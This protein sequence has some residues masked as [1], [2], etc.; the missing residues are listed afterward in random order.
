MKKK[1]I[2]DFTIPEREYIRSLANFTDRENRLFDLYNNED[3]SIEECAELM[4][5]SVSTINRTAKKMISKII[6]II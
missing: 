3:M 2:S 4:H 5:C 1:D 6:R